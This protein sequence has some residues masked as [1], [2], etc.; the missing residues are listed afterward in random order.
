R[1]KLFEAKQSSA[2]RDRHFVYFNELSEVM[3]ETFRSPMIFV[4]LDLVD[5]EVENFRAAFEWGL[6]NH[7]EENI[8]LAANFCAS[9]TTLSIPAE[10]VRIV[11]TAIERAR[12]LP[13]V[14]G[15]AHI[16]RQKLI[17]RALFAQGMVGLGVGNIPLVIQALKE[18]ISIS[19]LTGDKQVLGY[20]LGMYYTA[21]TFINAPDGEAA[22]REALQIFSQEVNDSFGL[23]IAYMNMARVAANKGDE[24]EKERYFGK[25]RETVR[26]MPKSFQIS[27]FLLGIGLDER[28]R[29]NYNA[30]RKIFED[31]LEIF[32]RLHSR[33]FILVMRSE[34]GHV[35]R[36]T[37]NLTQARSIYQETI[38]GWQELGNRSA[39]AH[40]LECFGFIAI[41][42]EEP[43][44][45]VKLFGAAEALRERIQA[46]M[47][48]YERVEYDQA[49]AR[50]RS[51]LTEAEFNALWADVGSM[52]MEQAIEFA[53]EK[54]DG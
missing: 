16:H 15:E 6:E 50:L 36:Q 53:L 22:A 12:T 24:S 47:A 32:R 35:E 20:S 42:K 7:V 18:S 37:G 45:A 9:S 4:R 38:K 51:M 39:V 52:T 8:R 10:G 41:V 11:T 3:W 14:E 25:L 33:N 31:G 26:E 40:E 46:P 17:A 23:G 54:T 5:D 19:R 13:S 44:R 2:A 49:V 28:I 48:D 21:T 34:L 30:A 43:Q 1:E 29:G 27:M